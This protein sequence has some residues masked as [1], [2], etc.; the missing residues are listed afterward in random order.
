MM[1]KE[2]RMDDDHRTTTERGSQQQAQG[3]ASLSKAW[4]GLAAA[5][6]VLPPLATYVLAAS[7]GESG[8]GVFVLLSI[9]VSLV[10]AGVAVVIARPWAVWL[11]TATSFGRLALDAWIVRSMEALRF[12]D[13]IQITVGG[14]DASRP[15]QAPPSETLAAYGGMIAASAVLVITLLLIIKAR[16]NMGAVLF[17][18]TVPGLGLIG[19]MARMH[20]SRGADSRVADA[21]LAELKEPTDPEKLARDLEQG[22]KRGVPESDKSKA[23]LGEIDIGKFARRIHIDTG[24]SAAA[25][26]TAMVRRDARISRLWPRLALVGAVLPWIGAGAM[27]LALGRSRRTGDPNAK[28][29]AS[30]LAAWGLLGLDT[31]LIVSCGYLAATSEAAASEQSRGFGAAANEALVTRHAALLRSV[32]SETQMHSDD[33]KA[34]PMD[35]ELRN[36]CEYLEKDVAKVGLARA[37]QIVSDLPAVC[38]KCVEFWLLELEGKR[39]VA[40]HGTA[41]VRPDSGELSKGLQQLKQTAMPVDDKQRERIEDLVRYTEDRPPKRVELATAAISQ[42]LGAIGLGSA[43]VTFRWLN[44]LRILPTEGEA[45]SWEKLVALGRSAYDIVRGPLNDNAITVEVEFSKSGRKSACFEDRLTEAVRCRYG[46]SRIMVESREGYGVEVDPTVTAIR[47][48]YGGPEGATCS[49]TVRNLSKAQQRTEVEC[50]LDVRIGQSQTKRA[51][52]EPPVLGPGGSG[53]YTI[54]FDGVSDY[55]PR[56]RTAVYVDGKRAAYFNAYAAR[57]DREQLDKHDGAAQR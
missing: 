19:S 38:S 48:E 1:R 20:L 4:L 45:P 11:L 14:G 54:A 15:L 46:D 52:T 55:S 36:P 53:S 32:I 7:H 16:P 44:T 13:A 50:S 51:A 18:V 42:K 27:L 31:L 33:R 6:L 21:K 40:S 35:R 28:A 49:G 24:H 8:S 25:L 5:L 22:M 9:G 12:D 57:K 41:S 34:E 56:M 47:S 39:A 3:Q 30:F 23:A 10:A 37:Q 17:A 29:K 43:R 2:F 26:A